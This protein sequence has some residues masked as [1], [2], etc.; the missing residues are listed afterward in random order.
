MD[1]VAAAAF[2][3]IVVI[4][5]LPLPPGWLDILLVIN[6]SFSIITLLLT[7]FTTN[8]RELNIFPSVLLTATLFRLALNIS[9]TRLILSRADAGKVIQAFGQFVVGG[10]YVV[11]LVI[12]VIITVIQFVVITNGAGRIAEVAARF[13][14]DALPGKQMSI[15]ADFNA[16]LI[17]EE[18][19]RQKRKELQTEADFFGAMD[20]ASKFVRGDA[21]AGIVIVLINIIGGLVVGVLQQGYS[22]QEATQIYIILTVGD[23]LVAQIPA[24]LI[25]TAAGMLVTRST[26]EASFGEEL[27]SQFLGYPRVLMLTAGL[28]FLLGLVPGLPAWPFLTLAL[29]CGLLSYILT[30]EQQQKRVEEA[31]VSAATHLS[32]EPDDPGLLLKVE[33]LEIEI[34]YNLISLTEVHGGGSLLERITKA[35]RKV[36]SELGIIIQPVRVRDN[37]HLPPN[38]YLFKLK[39]N[40]IGRGQLRPGMLLALCPGGEFPEQLEGISTREPTFNLPAIWIDEQQKDK[41]EMLGCTV[42]D[43]ATVLITHFTEILKSHA[44][45]LLTR[46]TVK[47][48]IDLVKESCPAVV[49]ELV[50]DLLTLGEIQKVLQN[51]L[52]EGIPVHDLETILEELADQARVTRDVDILTERV[53]EALQRTITYLFTSPGEPLTVITL[54]PELEKEIA[55]SLKSTGKGILPVLG[56]QK[57]QQLIASLEKLLH[58]L[59]AKGEAAPVILTSPGIRLPL[60]RFLEGFFPQLAVLSVHEI[61]PEIKVESA[62]V[63]SIHEG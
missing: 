16:G 51:L 37:L 18:T 54:A 55:N 6:I 28:L 38:D 41:A 50:P 56:P 24:I 4:M 12:F 17:D 42:V 36:I 25:S 1:L 14:L 34:G 15:D 33:L 63:I 8:T 46:Q 62:G 21:I 30:R 11:G 47:E 49:E 60:R 32:A 19:A 58:K 3:G 27:A 29:F 48:M 45:E 7:L 44:H 20:G 59:E 57:M 53:R 13:T 22:L 39:G 40:L 43:A 52:R 23:G 61:L 10:N 9:S 35:R 2:I 5:I 31:E 26:A